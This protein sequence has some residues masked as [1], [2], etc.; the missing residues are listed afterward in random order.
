MYEKGELDRTTVAEIWKVRSK[1][2]EN[3]QQE[4]RFASAD[5]VKG[6]QRTKSEERRAKLGIQRQ[7]WTSWSMIFLCLKLVR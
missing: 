2:A 1:F 5:E 3:I 6:Q 4:Y 7:R